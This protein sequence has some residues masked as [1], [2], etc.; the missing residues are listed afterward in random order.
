MAFLPRHPTNVWR[1]PPPPPPMMGF[2]V[3]P[4]APMF[5]VPTAPPV[6]QK[7]EAC[8]KKDSASY[9]GKN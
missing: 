5:G 2:G 1:P 7:A 9:N 6:K 3:P 8:R 4:P